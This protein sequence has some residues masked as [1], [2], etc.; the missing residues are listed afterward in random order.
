MRSDSARFVCGAPIADDVFGFG[1]IRVIRIP[2]D[3]IVVPCG[4][5]SDNNRDNIALGGTVNVRLTGKR[6]ADAVNVYC[7]GIGQLRCVLLCRRHTNTIACVSVDIKFYFKQ[8]YQPR[9][10]A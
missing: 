4:V 10:Q 7:L 2:G 5:L 9:S 6:V 3:L 8:S 1:G